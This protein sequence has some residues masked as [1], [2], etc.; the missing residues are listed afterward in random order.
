M[1]E[2]HDVSD[3]F[4]ACDDLG[5][6]Q[7]VRRQRSLIILALILFSFLF[8]LGRHWKTSVLGVL[9]QLHESFELKISSALTVSRSMIQQ[10]VVNDSGDLESSERCPRPLAE[11]SVRLTME[12]CQQL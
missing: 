5:F 9:R 8:V 11:I 1:R 6:P 4:V 10:C 3:P 12:D 2:T 7:S